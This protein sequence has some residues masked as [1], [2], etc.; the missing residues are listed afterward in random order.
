M[1]R[2][3]FGLPASRRA[4]AGVG[5]LVAGALGVGLLTVPLLDDPG[6]TNSPSAAK[7]AAA[8]PLTQESAQQKAVSTG[9]RVEV[10]ALRDETSTTYAR[11]DG[12]FELVA[13]GAP[14]RAKVGGVWNPVDTTLTETADGGW[15]PRATVDPVVFSGGGE[16]SG[17]TS[18]SRS[19]G[20]DSS[21]VHS[22]GTAVRSAVYTVAGGGTTVQAAADASDY[23]ELAS[24]TSDGHEVTLS[25]PGALPEP[26]ISGSSALYR[27]VFDGVDLL[28]T[29]QASGFSHVLIVHSAEAATAAA[30]TG[31]SYGLSSPDLTFHLDPVTKVVTGRDRDGREIAVS[32]TPYLWD[33]AGRTAVTQG[34]DPEP[35]EEG[36][37]P[38]PSYSEESGAPVPD[39]NAAPEDSLDTDAPVEPTTDPAAFHGSA[40]AG[41]VVVRPAA[42]T[43][44]VTAALTD[45]QVFAL[46]GLA[47][48]DPGTHLATADAKL[49]SPGAAST[50][51][52]LLPDAKLLADEDTVYPVFIDP[53][54]YGKTKNWTTAY[55]KYPTSSFYDGANYNTGTTEARVGFESTTWGLSRSFFRLG[56]STGI[57][58]ATI[59]SASIRL[60]E[61]YAWS[62]SA[63]EMQVWL[64]GS[65]SSKTTWNN[66]PDWKSE[67]GT[68]SF[69]HGYNSSC[70]D[71][72][73]SYDAK[74]VAQ[75]AADGGWSSMTIGLR[76]TTEDSAYSWKKFRAEG[77]SAPKLTLVYNRKPKTPTSVAQSPGG[78]CDRTTPY[79]HIGKRDLT[80][81]AVSSDA[82]D[83]STKQD[84]KYLDF[85]LWRTGYGDDKI[86]D[87]NVTVTSAGK[88]SVTIA[89]TSF[90][91][92]Y[93]Y[94]WRVRAIDSSGA[95][96]PYAPTSDPYVCRFIFDSGKPNEPLVSS[97]AFPAAD[98]DGTIW[99][100][101]KSGT[102]GTFV[103]A[104]DEDTDVTKFEW[105]FNTTTYNSS[106]TVTAGASAT[107][108]LTPPAAGP[109][110]LYVRAVDSSGNPSLGTKYLFYVTPRD[111]ADKPGDTTGDGTP[112]LYAIT[113]GGNLLMYPSSTAGDL[114]VGLEAGQ[115]DGV[116][117]LSD[118]DGDGEDHKPGYW[119]GSDGKPALIAHGGDALGGDGLGDIFARMP[120][121]EL[122]VYPGDGYGSVD[123]SRRMTV[124][125]PSGAPDPAAFDQIIVGDYDA[126]G[127][128]DLFATAAGG[129][130]WAFEGYTGATFLKQTKIA[131][132]AWLERDLVSVGDHDADGAPDLLW[133]SGASSRLYLRYGVKDS[134]GGST[135]ASLTTAA[136]SKTGADEVYAEGWSTTTVPV[137]HLYGTPDVTG[138]KIPDIWALASTGSI[139]F[140]KGGASV[141]GTGAAVISSSSEWAT[142]KLTFG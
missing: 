13:Y 20:R 43:D 50:G 34:G 106:K 55:K 142:T 91:N 119:K 46:P 16:G 22:G 14:V 90:T 103:L 120:D 87:K 63:R 127:R 88:A 107:V 67:I 68:K 138:D 62:C 15:A 30:S 99:S 18:G 3:R 31:L 33:S 77:D 42:Y 23:T 52:S 44:V 102:A 100:S 38:T 129:A 133:R 51:L 121:G 141:I 2:R 37:E 78:N 112:D 135:I 132:T 47:G 118:L 109:N 17:A 113:S 69:S 1:E 82:D 66:Q 128:A 79:I 105:A 45:E 98:E 94:S 40:R 139:Y 72:Y 124:R 11:P 58:G 80:L 140:Y 41:S 136:D 110:V 12:S 75:D 9:K 97:T 122:Y 4:R 49:S 6:P 114:H 29:A 89:K 96:S 126:D 64:T 59:S 32:P 81:S 28:L 5:A 61:T 24:L 8:D 95:A 65:I 70:P 19:R 92:G 53:T 93:Q 101:V 56:W 71:A 111:A 83:T 104:P 85:E 73:V 60:R 108:S 84:L 115:E 57:K 137:T 117:L 26:V 130:L 131:T 36:P 86:L 125:L 54:I 25:W 74:S 76:A 134:A 39:E 27:N 21:A 123:I 48:P 7:K 116:G 35:A 10:T